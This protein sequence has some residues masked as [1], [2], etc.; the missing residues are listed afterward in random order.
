MRIYVLGGE[1]S[2]EAMTAQQSMIL[3][4][5]LSEAERLLRDLEH[6]IEYWDR[7]SRKATN[8]RGMAICLKKRARCVKM[9]DEVRKTVG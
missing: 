2:G 6:T 7:Q 9:A 5:P 8:P 1:Q 4:A 3:E